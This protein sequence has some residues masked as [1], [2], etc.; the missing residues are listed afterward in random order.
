M[1]DERPGRMPPIRPHAKQPDGYFRLLVESVRDYAIFL[2][3]PDG[4]IA[5][6]NPGAER[7]KGYTAEQIIGQHYRI[8]YPEQER[9]ARTP[10]RQLETA[11]REGRI[12]RRGWRLRQD[13]TRFW[14]QV[15]ITALF[16]GDSLVGFAKVTEDLTD[17]RKL[18]EELRAREKQLA[19][20]QKIAHVGSWEWVPETDRLRWSR[21]LSRIYGIEPDQA[22][23]LAGYLDLIHPDDRD[24]MRA[25]VAR[26]M[27]TGAPLVHEHRVVTPAGEERWV[28]GRGEVVRDERGQVIGMRGTAIDITE[29]K[30]AE[31]KSRRLVA[32]QLARAEAE[33]TAQRMGLLAEA[34]ALV[35]ASLQFEETLSTVAWLAVPS[36]ADW[37]AVD[38]V[39][40]S[41]RLHRLA[42][43]HIDPERVAIAREI[44]ERYP[45][46]PAADRGVYAVLRTGEPELLEEIPPE[47]LADLARDE[48]HRRR[49][50]ELGLHSSIMVPIR[51]A[52]RSLG[53]ITFINAESERRYSREDLIVAEELAGRAALA[54]ENAQLHAAE[55]EARQRAEQATTRIARLQSIT[56]ELSEAVT[57]E[58]VASVIVDAGV[59]A[60]GANS[61]SL[62]LAT[63]DDP[64]AFRIV[65]SIG[66]PSHVVERYRVFPPD[67]PVP[68]ASAV[69]LGELVLVRNPRE[70]AER[71]PQ[72]VEIRGE[73]AIGALAAVPLRSGERVLGGLGFTYPEARDF[74]AEDRDFLMAIGRQCVQALE[75]ARLY[76]TEHA[77]RRAAEA[78]SEAKSQFVAMMS[79]ELRTPLAAIIGYQELLSEEIVGPINDRQK[80]QLSRIRASASHLR[81][82]INQILSL[83]RIE[84]GREQVFPE[85]IDLAE[86]ARDVAILMERE[87]ESK[88]LSFRVEIPEEETDAET[89]AGKVRQ[90][91]LNLLSNAIK[92]TDSGEIGIR[93]SATDAEARIEVWD[94]GIGIPA[95]DQD[96]V[97]EAFTQ[98]DQSMT[99]RAGGT[100]LGLPVSRH[101][102][103]LLGGGLALDSAPD[104]GSTFVLTL[105][106]VL[107][108]T[109]PR[110]AAAPPDAA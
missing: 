102:A 78:A 93:F 42:A 94:T 29:L 71:F 46:D 37:C 56:A 47:M 77:A 13:G 76:E 100:G 39:D 90:I 45:P 57:P 75:R 109:P 64:S 19:E 20:A 7:L 68:L 83:S 3:D 98:V 101:L 27:E 96:R 53:V 17:L 105:P 106:L 62:I 92:F 70:L 26:S 104:R 50:D 23:D 25:A 85:T 58:A 30:Q 52:D 22:L 54:I 97:F 72:L 8:F 80:D 91:L 108:D 24:A 38:M 103:H 44:H 88:G 60:L 34:S 51:V 65:R 15:V 79:H 21:E 67:A 73:Q 6:W 11:V 61:G 95:D 31:Q 89:D 69:R 48:E 36:F 59:A 18:L 12:E 86:L 10:E 43:A 87:V 99:R 81:D 4:H 41:G 63:K 9:A 28:Q 49:L 55:R 33:R 2:L 35:G 40:A 1:T 107:P 32:E 84:A 74:V 14:A 5:S 82:L 110:E 66:V 16:Q